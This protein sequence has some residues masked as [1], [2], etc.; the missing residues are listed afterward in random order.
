MEHD[1]HREHAGVTLTRSL[2]MEEKGRMDA[3]GRICQDRGRA[4]GAAR[5]FRYAGGMK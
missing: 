2:K 3:T 4:S 1:A 5:E